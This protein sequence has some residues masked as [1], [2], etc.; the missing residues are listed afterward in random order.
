MIAEERGEPLV[1][2]FPGERYTDR[3]DLSRCLAPP[4]DVIDGTERQ[5]L[6][7]QDPCNVVHFILPAGDEDRY[8]RAA[9]VLADWRRDGVLAR[10]DEPSVY[11]LRQHFT[12]PDGRRH[13]RT[14]VIGAVAAESF[15]T[16]RVRPHERTHAGPK[17]D[18]LALLEASHA[19]FE[20]LFMLA[21][22]SDGMLAEQVQAVVEEPPTTQA[23][24]QDVTVGLWRVS[25]SRADALA[26]TAGREGLYIADGHH[27][28]ETAVAFAQQYPSARR[29]PALI[30]SLQDPGLVVLATHRMLDGPPIPEEGIRALRDSFK[31]RQLS[32]RAEARA[33]LEG[34]RDRGTSCVLLTPSQTLA[35]LLKPGASLGEVPFAN[36]PSVASLDVA[37]IDALVVERLG[38]SAGGA[39]V[40]YS[41]DSQRV[42]DAVDGGEVAAGI[43][44][45]PTKVEHVLDVADA[46]AVMPPKS[47]YFIPKVASGLVA[48]AY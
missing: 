29:L 41:A 45:N 9:E 2:P 24:L 36:E 44:L 35:L 22:D 12:T 5:R 1:V 30:V 4:Y 11:V 16:G 19:T 40:R 27:R 14:G 10:D 3:A 28:Y 8:H 23:T 47:T 46:R 6:A 17:R 13:T 7:A 15:D 42:I 37:R 18:R 48:M 21:R 25:G 31:I 34:L 33:E 43:L 20:S 38:E 39:A 26:T 32:S